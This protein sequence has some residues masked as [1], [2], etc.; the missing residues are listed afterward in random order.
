MRVS[1]CW[2][3]YILL[4]EQFEVI[5][6]RRH[7]QPFLVQVQLVDGVDVGSTPLH[8]LVGV[9]GQLLHSE[10]ENTLNWLGTFL[11][12]QS[13]SRPLLDSGCD[14]DRGLKIIHKKHRM[15]AS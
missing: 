13:R 11:S 15:G 8:H 1:I 2:C 14:V 7:T 5:S 3:T 9:H 4:T 12:Q 10:E 6:L